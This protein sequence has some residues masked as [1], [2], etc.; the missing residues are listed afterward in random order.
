MQYRMLPQLFS[1]AESVCIFDVFHISFRMMCD[2]AVRTKYILVIFDSPTGGAR[3][4]P[5]HPYIITSRRIRIQYGSSFDVVL[6]LDLSAPHSSSH[7]YNWNVVHTMCAHADESANSQNKRLAKLNS[8]F[9]CYTK[10]IGC[11]VEST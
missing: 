8:Q 10:L 11:C 9:E 2:T 4:L 3:A 1:L 5:F 6:P 7:H